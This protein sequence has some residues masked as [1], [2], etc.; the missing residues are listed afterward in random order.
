MSPMSSNRRSDIAPN[1]ATDVS[2]GVGKADLFDFGLVKLWRGY[3]RR[4]IVRHPKRSALTFV[5]LFGASSFFALSSA[6]SYLVTTNLTAKLDVVSAVANPNRSQI[7]STAKPILNAEALIT[8]DDNLKK[9]MKQADLVV[10]YNTNEPKLAKLK[11]KMFFGKSPGPVAAEEDILRLL[12]AGVSAKADTENDSV[13]ISVLW[14]DPVQ[15]RDIAREAQKNFLADRREA[16]IQPLKDAL[17]ILQDKL[18][19]AIENVQN[20]RSQLGIPADSREPLPESSPLKEALT[21][22]QVLSG[23]K[24]DAEIEVASAEQGFKYRYSEVRPPEL[25][26]APVKGSLKLIV[27]GLILACAG[28]VAV[29]VAADARKGAI[30]EPWQVTR[31]L[32]LPVLAELKRP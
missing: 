7:L 30:I 9:L 21:Q 19:I 4:S 28:A 2:P 27:F 31:K 32:N 14:N 3:A 29:A 16:E 5:L 25:P 18:N 6:K 17:A 20:L 13:T 22:Q 10:R 8:A 11:R 1:G 24:L 26:L 12:R 23:R 15:A